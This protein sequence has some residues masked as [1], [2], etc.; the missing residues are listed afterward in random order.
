MFISLGVGL[1]SCD[2]LSSDD[3]MSPA[4]LLD[5]ITLLSQSKAIST[6]DVVRLHVLLL[7]PILVLLPHFSPHRVDSN[8]RE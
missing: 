5:E 7:C 4:V 6:L 1:M 3:V 2:R 8:V